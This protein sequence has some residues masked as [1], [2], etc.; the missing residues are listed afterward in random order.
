MISIR[1][2]KNAKLGLIEMCRMIETRGTIVEIG[3]Y[4]GDSTEIFARH[5][6]QVIAIDP[7]VNGYDDED[8]ASY[9][10]DMS[11][12]EAQFDEMAKNY[13][14]IVKIKA[15][16]IDAVTQIADGS[17]D[18]VYIDGLHTRDGVTQDREAWL[19]KIKP[20]GYLCGHDYQSKFQGVIDAVN[21][22]RKPD[23]I[24]KDT[25][26]LIKL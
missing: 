18:V 22:F 16:S 23:H 6:K 13:E 20:G 21:E 25:S 8:A 14:N 7:W 10:H 2:A 3:S 1:N 17:I 12:I 24:F 5:F 15:K 26:W 19:S 11:I 4:V 9:Q